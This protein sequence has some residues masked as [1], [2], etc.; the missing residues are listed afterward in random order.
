MFNSLNN[1]PITEG[2]SLEVA[3]TKASFLSAPLARNA[4][5]LRSADQQS[6]P[7]SWFTGD[8]NL[9]LPR[10]ESKDLLATPMFR[11]ERQRDFVQGLIP[12][13]DEPLTR[14][15]PVTSDGSSGLVD[16]TPI[17]AK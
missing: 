1:F 17:Y 15:E 12:V 10:E 14:A 9:S 8:N 5:Q 4:W 16:T 3:N 11:I 2:Q 7:Q 13:F 6:L